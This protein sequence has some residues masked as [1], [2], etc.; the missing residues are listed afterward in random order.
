MACSHSNIIILHYYN[1]KLHLYY[2][3]DKKKKKKKTCS[4]Y[5]L[6]V[7]YI[8]A[9]SLIPKRYYFHFHV[10]LLKHKKLNHNLED[11]MIW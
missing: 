9:K 11:L 7:C 10:T 3:N 5:T 6:I 1:E 8:A 4:T 2:Y